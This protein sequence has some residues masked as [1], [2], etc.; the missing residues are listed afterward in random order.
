VSCGHAHS[1]VYPLDLLEL[2]SK[3][4]ASV[5]WLVVDGLAVYVDCIF[6]PS[7]PAL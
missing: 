4:E 5:K 3:G 2:L 1:Q 7:V 6:M